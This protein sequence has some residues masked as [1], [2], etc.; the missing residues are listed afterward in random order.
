MPELLEVG[1]ARDP[2]LV[3][4]VACLNQFVDGPSILTAGALTHEN[5]ERIG[6]PGQGA[7]V[8]CLYQPMIQLVWAE[9]SK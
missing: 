9:Q 5:Q 1:P 6:S 3:F 8:P 2:D 7:G 4:G